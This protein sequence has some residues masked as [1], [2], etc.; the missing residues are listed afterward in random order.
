[1]RPATANGIICPAVDAPR[2]NPNRFR[3]AA[4]SDCEVEV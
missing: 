1:M 2:A 4:P 3:L